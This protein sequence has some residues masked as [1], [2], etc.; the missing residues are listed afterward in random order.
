[1]TRFVVAPQ[2][3]GS[4]SARAMRLIDGAEAIAGDLPRSA[5]TRIEVPAL[6]RFVIYLKGRCACRIARLCV[7]T[8]RPL[9]ACRVIFTPSTRGS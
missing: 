8:P 4:P 3:Q 1:M 7:H 2:W 6:G 5:L 9:L